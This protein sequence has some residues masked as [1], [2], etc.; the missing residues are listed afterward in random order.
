MLTGKKYGQLVHK[1]VVV[2]EFLITESM[3]NMADMLELVCL[4]KAILLWRKFKF[5]KIHLLPERSK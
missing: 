1:L 3:E 2:L 4:T 5:S